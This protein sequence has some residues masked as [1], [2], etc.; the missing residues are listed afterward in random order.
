[1]GLKSKSQKI[2]N[3]V[4]PL[5]LI[6]AGLPMTTSS[7]IYIFQFIHHYANCGIVI[8]LLPM[9]EI[10]AI[11]YGCPLFNFIQIHYQKLG[12]LPHWTLLFAWIFATP[13]FLLAI[14]AVSLGNFHHVTG[15]QDYEYP[16][17]CKIVGICIIIVNIAPIFGFMLYKLLVLKPRK[18]NH[19]TFVSDAG[20]KLTIGQRWALIVA[21]E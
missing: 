3:I 21:P 14:F 4:L 11:A 15:L 2:F 20:G 9:L 7:G 18:S 16:Y 5:I 6:C 10:Y 13:L 1:L 19:T 12:H 8:F 17:W